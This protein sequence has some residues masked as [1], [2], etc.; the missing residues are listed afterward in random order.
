MKP[1]TNCNYLQNKNT[2]LCSPARFSG[3][4][5]MESEERENP[6][7]KGLTSLH[8]AVALA[9]FMPLAATAEFTPM[10]DSSMRSTVGQVG[11][12]IDLSAIV[13][14]REIAYE[15]QGFVI[16]ENLGIGGSGP[17]Q[18]AL[19]RAVTG[20]NSLDNLRMTIDIAGPG[21][22]D[23]AAPWGLDKFN[24]SVWTAS[25][26]N[27]GDHGEVAVPITDG[28]MVIGFGAQ[29]QNE[30]VDFGLEIGRVGL[31]KSGPIPPATQSPQIIM[32]NVLLTGV[33]GPTDIVVD[34]DSDNININSYFSLDGSLRTDLYVP[35]LLDWQEVGFDFR[36]HNERGEDVL[37]YTNGA[38][39]VVSFAHLQAD[40][41][42]STGP[43]EG[44]RVNLTDL[45]GDLDTTNITLADSPTVGSLYWTDVQISADLNI[46]G[47]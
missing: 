3:K 43:I 45:S 36:M 33:L 46:Y 41:G 10:T 37:K 9:T 22:S 35:I 27:Q 14:V 40:I 11:V 44:L 7:M 2:L 47:H 42:A 23:L 29:N 25:P 28:D 21:G 31:R 1:L 38:G 24:S 39:E 5:V 20:G 30:L 6:G 4:S 19:G 26:D 8:Y 17:I 32:D 15:D 12:T 13:T 18:S 34:A 16:I